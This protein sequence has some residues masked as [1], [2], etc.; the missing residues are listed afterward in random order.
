MNHQQVATAVNLPKWE[1]QEQLNPIASLLVKQPIRVKRENL[2]RHHQA[3]LRRDH[4]QKYPIISQVSYSQSY[5]LVYWLIGWET[6][7]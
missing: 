1:T 4:H 7:R 5:Y 6:W 3:E 2:T